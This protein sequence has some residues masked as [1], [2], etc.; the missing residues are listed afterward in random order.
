MQNR[1]RPPGGVMPYRVLDP[2]GRCRRFPQ[3]VVEVDPAEC[4]GEIVEADD[5]A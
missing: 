5:A 4:G 2:G 3:A 1:S